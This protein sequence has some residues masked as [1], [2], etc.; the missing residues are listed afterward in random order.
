[1]SYEILEPKCSISFEHRGTV[2]LRRCVVHLPILVDANTT[3]EIEVMGDS[4]S[5]PSVAAY[6]FNDDTNS[7]ERK[8]EYKRLIARA[9]RYAKLVCGIPAYVDNGT[10]YMRALD[11]IDALLS[12]LNMLAFDE[13]HNAPSAQALCKVREIVRAAK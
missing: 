6:D 1:M 2:E 9:E 11:D 8:A 10:K 4:S 13:R 7:T 3:L 12:S 5:A